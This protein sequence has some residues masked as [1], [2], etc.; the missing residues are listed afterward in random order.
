M[1]EKNYPPPRISV[2]IAIALTFLFLVLDIISIFPALNWLTTGI[3][4]V[5]NV[6]LS[7]MGIGGIV[8]VFSYVV[9]WII[10][11]IPF[12]SILP[13]LTIVWIIT[14][15]FDRFPWILPERIRAKIEEAGKVAE[16]VKSGGKKGANIL[17]DQKVA[18]SKGRMAR[19]DRKGFK[20]LKRGLGED[21]ESEFA[22]NLPPGHPEGTPGGV[23]GGGA[24]QAQEPGRQGAG[25]PEGERGTGGVGEAGGESRTEGEEAQNKEQGG[26]EPLTPEEQWDQNMM[27]GRDMEN[28]ETALFETQQI[29][30]EIESPV[31]G[32]KTSGFDPRVMEPKKTV[33]GVPPTQAADNNARY[34]NN[35]VDLRGR[36]AG[37][38]RQ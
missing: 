8:L 36:R 31:L 17:E 19:T 13:V 21:V 18:F 22:E 5:I 12:L 15:I 33:P 25:S 6:T 37:G 26:R 3:S 34:N 11:L 9:G 32:S 14:I 28:L 35:E 20:G 7:F 16:A 10:E 4:G 1:G 29:N 27:R 38:E 24:G 2:P 23:G 30:A